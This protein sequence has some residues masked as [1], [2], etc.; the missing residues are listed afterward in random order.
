MLPWIVGAVVVGVGAYLL[1]DA[2][3]DNKRARNRY[4]STL[5]EAE[6]NIK[7][8]YYNAQ[9]IDMLDKLHKVK[10]AKYKILNSTQKQIKGSKNNLKKI[11]FQLKKLKD[12]LSILFFEKHGTKTREEKREI[13]KDINIVIKARRELFQIRDELKFDISQL[14]K[15]LEDVRREI[16]NIHNDIGRIEKG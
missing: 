1:D 2:K 3:S 8:A 4:N 9:D 16:K 13:Q 12:D 10:R 7:E 5:K 14:E 11:N 6:N 15:K